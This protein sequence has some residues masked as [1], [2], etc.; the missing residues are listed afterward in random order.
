MG[1]SATADAHY[2]RDMIWSQLFV[3]GDVEVLSRTEESLAKE[4][5]VSR[6]TVRLAL[7]MLAN[8]GLVTRKRGIGTTIAVDPVNRTA[9]DMGMSDLVGGREQ[10]VRRHT[11]G[12]TVV[13]SSPLLHARFGESAGGFLRWERTTFVDDVPFST[14][15]TYLPLRWA[16]PLLEGDEFDAVDMFKLVRSLAPTAPV[17][18]TRR[19]RAVAADARTSIQL[20]VEPG[21][22]VVHIERSIEDAHGACLELGYAECR[23]DRFTL[24]YTTEYD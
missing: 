18:A 10:R 9:K 16:A 19:M 4:Y 5:Q 11:V 14:W 22:P 21:V 1:R 3:D 17:R 15:T 8:E 2:V 24:T 12:K 20:R 23:S 7:A 6:N 13:A